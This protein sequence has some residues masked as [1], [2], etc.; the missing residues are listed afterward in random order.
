GEGDIVEPADLARSYDGDLR[1]ISVGR[2]DEEK[3]PLLLPD[4]L[5]SLRA[6]DPRWRMIICGDGPLEQALAGRVRELG[7]DEACDLVGHVPIDAGLID[8]YRGSHVFLHVSWT[9]G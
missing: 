5:A 2:L 7:L 1:V 3:N 6:T 8:L 4:V 9:E